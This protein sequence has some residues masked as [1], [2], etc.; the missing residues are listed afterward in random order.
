MIKIILQEYEV[1]DPDKGNYF[2]LR[3]EAKDGGY[4][5]WS[6]FVVAESDLRA[7]FAELEDFG[8]EFRGTPE[9]R[10]GWPDEVYFR[11]RLKKWKISGA[12][13]VDV[14]IAAP[15]RSKASSAGL[16]S[17]RLSFGFPSDPVQFDEFLGGL[18]E[19]INGEGKEI[20]LEGNCE[21]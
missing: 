5:G 6:D 1:N 16:R 2:Y 9:L 10:A 7:F 17:H 11:L 8:K 21:W 4:T 18:R 3:G 15:V 14:E 12:L 19:F 20:S 13:W